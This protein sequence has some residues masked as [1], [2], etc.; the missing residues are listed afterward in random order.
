ME[1]Q[2]Y[3]REIDRVDQEI[4]KDIAKRMNIADEIGSLKERK[5]LEVKDEE[6]EEEV[7]QNFEK[8]FKK[9]DLEPE[10]GRKLANLLME[11]SRDQQ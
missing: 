10:K 3:R 6:R 5:G 4:V 9:E 1:L 7:R 8:L 2:D 11:L